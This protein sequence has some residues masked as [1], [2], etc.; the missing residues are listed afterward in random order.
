MVFLYFVSFACSRWYLRRHSCFIFNR[1]WLSRD[2]SWKIVKASL[3]HRS[4]QNG[5]SR[6]SLSAY[7]PP[8][9][10]Q[11]SYLGLTYSSITLSGTSSSCPVVRS[12]RMGTGLVSGIDKTCFLKKSDA[13]YTCPDAEAKGSSFFLDTVF[14]WRPQDSWKKLCSWPSKFGSNSM[15][16]EEM[17]TPM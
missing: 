10:T 1:G 3:L 7:C 2:G 4:I 11:S 17:L 16:L 14:G 5:F 9:S 8:A 13:L 6:P 15:V 12:A